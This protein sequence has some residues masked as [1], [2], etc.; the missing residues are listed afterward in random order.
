MRLYTVY[1]FCMFSVVL[2]AQQDTILLKDLVVT[3]NRLERNQTQFLLE[4]ND[5]VIQENPPLLTEILNFNTP[6]YFKE[7]GY[8]MVS[9]PSF[10]GTTASQTSVLWNGISINS[11]FL[12]Q[13]DFNTVSSLGY[14]EIKIKPGGGSVAHGSG[15]IGGSVHLRQN[16]AFNQGLHAAL[17]FGY[18]SFNTLK[19]GAEVKHSTEHLSF[20]IGYNRNSSDNDYEVED[21]NYTNYNGQFWNNALN[22]NFA[23]KINAK[24]Q[25][26]LFLEG[27]QDERHFSLTEPT[28]NKTKYQNRNA[29]SLLQYEN[30]SEWMQNIVRVAWLNEYWE[31]FQNLEREA[32]SLGELSTFLVKYD[33]IFHLNSTMDISLFGEKTFAN[34]TGEGGGINQVKRNAG[35]AGVMFSHQIQP[36][37]FYEVGLRKEMN[38]DYESPLLFSFGVKMTPAKWYIIK[39]QISKNFRVP[40]FNDLYWEPGGN[41]D[42]NSENSLQFEFNNELS[43]HRQKINF[44]IYQNDID[45]MIRWVPGITGFW[46]PENVDKVRTYGYEI[47]TEFHKKWQNHHFQLNSSYAYTKAINKETNKQ[48]PYVPNYKI[49]GTLHHT[50]QNFSWYVQ[51]LWVDKIYTTT[52]E[53]VDLQLDDYAVFNF[54]LNYEIGN[55]PKLNFGG[56]I[57]N[58][59]N[60]AYEAYPYR[61]MPPRNYGIQLRTNF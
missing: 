37:L 29:R 2:F 52:N 31:Y 53:S 35:N 19:M 26:S 11:G 25:I 13:T 21:L 17:L 40:T 8:G 10:R 28:A 16:M 49:N 33:G 51:G 15:A 44:N 56:Y 39:T 38:S 18:G 41:P 20:K 22:T 57:K 1:L 23:Y 46:A 45:D 9:S 30:D 5:T 48:L 3:D 55:K 32:F 27:Y 6:I 59:W 50:Y 36:E 47:Y 12:G 14:D 42:L 24:N 34:A 60:R 4:L 58:L 61:V 43:F 7:N 54:G